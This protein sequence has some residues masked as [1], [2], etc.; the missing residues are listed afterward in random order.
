M[1]DRVKVIKLR[2]NGKEQMIFDLR[3]MAGMSRHAI[4]EVN[5]CKIT[6]D[7]HFSMNN[8]TVSSYIGLREQNPTEACPSA[9]SPGTGDY[10]R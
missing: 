6:S 7:S 5:F 4:Q 8:L 1:Y 2:L 9:R 10:G 3:I